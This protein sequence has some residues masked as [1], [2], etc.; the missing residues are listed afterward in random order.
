MVTD[1]AISFLKRPASIA[2]LVT[3]RIAFGVLMF[4]STLRFMFMGW[5]NCMYVN[6]RVFFPYYGF[7]WVKPL[8]PAGM[9]AVFTLLLIAS[10]FIAIG[11]LYRWSAIAFFILFTYVELIDKTNYLNHYYFIS[12]VSFLMIFV[13]ADRAFSLDNR[14]RGRS[15]A[16]H[17][18]YGWT[19]MLRLQMFIVY[20]FA[21]IA[22]VNHQWLI[23]A[24]PLK[25]WLPAFSHY[26]VIGPWMEAD[27]VAYA[28]SWFGCIYDLTIG[29]MLFSPRLVRP[30]YALVIIFHTATALFFNI[31]MFPYIMMVITLIFFPETAHIAVIARL[32][33]FFRYTQSS[34]DIARSS[35]PIAF[36]VLFFSIQL[37][38]PF[39][40]L[41]YKGDL[42]WTEQGYRFSWRVMLMEKAGTAFFTVRDSNG[43]SAIIDNSEYLTPMQ[44]KMMSTQPDMMVDFAKFLKAEYSN[45][46]F[47]DPV[48]NVESYVTL[49]GSGTR[50]FVK[51]DVDLASQ[52]NSFL[53]ERSYLHPF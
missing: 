5:V 15:D 1:R 11:L 40:Y 7:E 2:P 41:L 53:S 17:A 39:R 34:G 43:R 37:M 47:I 20:F 4:A 50:P 10:L 8:G 9:Y 22:K 18:Q 6:P 24:Q 31:G 45:K 51:Q 14:L 21:G 33:S 23:E 35:F 3:F 52:S 28:C 29:F 46:G 49:N 25:L 48:V 44:E 27:W 42:F 38:L 12:L 19:F 32:R 26:P 36:A 13:P 16:E 30:A